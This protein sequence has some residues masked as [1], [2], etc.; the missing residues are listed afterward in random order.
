MNMLKNNPEMLK[1]M[2]SML[3]DNNPLSKYLKNANSN[4]LSR[5][6]SLLGYLASCCT[7]LM[8]VYRFIKSNKLALGIFIASIIVYKYRLF[9]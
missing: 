5:M 9:G 4:D 3:G 1:S 6:V 7:G 8:K 2:S